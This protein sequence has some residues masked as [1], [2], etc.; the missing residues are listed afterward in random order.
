MTIDNNTGEVI[1]LDEAIK[2]THTFQINN[3][4]AIKSF[5]AGINKINC[6]LGQDDCMGIRFYNGEDSV[7]GKSNLVLVGV[8]KNGEDITQGVILER[9]TDCPTLCPKISDLIKPYTLYSIFLY[10]ALFAGILPLLVLFPKKRAFNISEP[11]VPFIW[12]T[13]I[14][15]LYELIGSIILKINVDYWF[16]IYSLLELLTILY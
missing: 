6:I 9:L 3:P 12:L 16:Q 14:A 13:T 11:I 7:T 10:T 8:D 4:D 1:S 2:Y 15:S 5:F